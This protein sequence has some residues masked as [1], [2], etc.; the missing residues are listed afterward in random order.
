MKL[1]LNIMLHSMA[2]KAALVASL[3]S[4]SPLPSLYN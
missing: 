4:Y 3:M 2:E 1:C